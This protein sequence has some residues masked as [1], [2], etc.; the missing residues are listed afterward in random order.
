MRVWSFPGLHLASLFL[1]QWHLTDRQTDRQWCCLTSD[2]RLPPTF[3]GDQP[4][5]VETVRAGNIIMTLLHFLFLI[6]PQT[7]TLLGWTMPIHSLH[8]HHQYTQSAFFSFSSSFA[9]KIVAGNGW[10]CSH[11]VSGTMYNP[12][13]TLL[14]LQAEWGADC[15]VVY[16]WEGS[17]PLW[18]T[19]AN[20][21]VWAVSVCS[22][23]ADRSSPDE[24]CQCQVTP[25]LVICLPTDQKRLEWRN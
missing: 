13:P 7:D 21:F 23:G 8:L 20:L 6:F 18:C 25:G 24:Y 16:W 22:R 9:T 15:S 10:S 11:W 19:S 4:V 14:T 5:Q 3:T 1:L 2:R 12:P 17:T